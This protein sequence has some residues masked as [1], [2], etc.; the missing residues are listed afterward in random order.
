MKLLRINIRYL[1]FLLVSFSFIITNAQAQK[2]R[3]V[4]AQ[5]KIIAYDADGNKIDSL[6]KDLHNQ[7]KRSEYLDQLQVDLHKVEVQMKKANTNVAR[8][9]LNKQRED[10]LM[11]RIALIEEI[12]DDKESLVKEYYI[13]AGA[14]KKKKNAKNAVNEFREKGF[15]PFVFYNKYRK[16]YYVCISYHRSYRKA[17]LKQWNLKKD[18]IDSWIYYWAQ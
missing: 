6:T 3:K 4:W 14:F 2:I 17:N 9:E 13:V 15:K 16:W 12:K 10:I 8:G 1:L 11:K 18:G 5:K 7:N